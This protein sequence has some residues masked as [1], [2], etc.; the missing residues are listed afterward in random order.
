MKRILTA[1]VVAIS[2]SGCITT[3]LVNS[4]MKAGETQDL[5]VV[6]HEGFGEPTATPSCPHGVASIGQGTKFGQGF[7]S[8]ITLGIYEPSTIRVAC[9]N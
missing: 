2:L 4:K 1:V 9:A 3:K 6:H 5:Q 8:G 7:M